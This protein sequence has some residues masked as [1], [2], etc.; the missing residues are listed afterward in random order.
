[1]ILCDKNGYI[2]L[3]CVVVGGFLNI[4]KV[5]INVGDEIKVYEMM[6]D[7]LIV[8]YIVCKNKNLFLCRFLMFENDFKKFFLYKKLNKGWNV[9]YYVVV[10]GSIEILNFFKDYGFDIIV[11]IENK[12]NI[13][14]IVCLYN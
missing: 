13:F 4:F 5:I 9:V 2:L 14:D 6:Y 11:V 10:V 1:M 8:L 3:Y 7:G 12:L